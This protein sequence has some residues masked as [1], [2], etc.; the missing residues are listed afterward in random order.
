MVNKRRSISIGTILIAIVSFAID[1]DA[2]AQSDSA[3]IMDLKSA[4]VYKTSK[5]V[6]WPENTFEKKK[7]TLII[8]VLGNKQFHKT[9]ARKMEKEKIDGHPLKV[10]LVSLDD[11]SGELHMLYID[12]SA[13]KAFFEADKNEYAESPILTLGDSTAFAEGGGIIQ[14]FIKNNKPSIK[15]NIDAATRKKLKIDI[16]LLQVSDVIRD[17]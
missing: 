2:W 1:P 9:L 14:I 3:T 13:T 4:L 16:R 8:G 5:L 12:S 15:I 6:T 10:V 11:D 17:T 7:E